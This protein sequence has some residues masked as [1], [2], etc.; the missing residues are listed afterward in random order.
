MLQG[1]EITV[2]RARQLRRK[3]TLHEVLLWQRL[4]QRPGGFKFRNQH[5]A[6]PYVFDFYCHEARLIVEVDGQSHG[7][8]DRPE[9]DAKRD[10]HFRDK[11]L[12]TFRIPARDVLHDA[13]AEAVVALCTSSVKGD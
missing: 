4:R 9:Y 2:R 5:P 3:M 1:D 12:R 8:G 7:M 11:G 10:A 6:T 13:A